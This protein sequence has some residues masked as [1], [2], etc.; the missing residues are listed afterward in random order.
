MQYQRGVCL[1]CR[2][3]PVLR[4]VGSGLSFVLA[5]SKKERELRD[6]AI[7]SMANDD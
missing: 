2:V 5:D 1:S 7:K 3:M 4:F 6:K